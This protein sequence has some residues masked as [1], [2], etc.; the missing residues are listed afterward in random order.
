[1]VSRKPLEFRKGVFEFAGASQRKAQLAPHY[2]IAGTQLQVLPVADGSL[3]VVAEFLGGVSQ[4]KKDIR[5]VRRQ[6]MC[7]IQERSRH[8]LIPRVRQNL[9]KTVK[10]VWLLGPLLQRNLEN[11]LCTIQMT[12]MSRYQAQVV[13]DVEVLGIRLQGACE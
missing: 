12:R 1:M 4:Q 6:P 9:G 8:H 3:F 2:V 13:K 5:P 11:L 10:S 7:P